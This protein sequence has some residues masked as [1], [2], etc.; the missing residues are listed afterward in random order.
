MNTYQLI[1][2]IRTVFPNVSNTQIRLDLD[3]AQK[4]LLSEV[5]LNEKSVL[6]ANPSVTTAWLLPSDFVSMNELVLFDAN[7]EP[8]YLE[9]KG[10]RYK[11]YQNYLVVYS[12]TS[13]VISGLDCTK[14]LL[15]YNSLPTTLSSESTELVLKEQYR[16]ALESYVLSKY[17]SK[18]PVE[19]ISNGQVVKAINLQLAQYHKTQYETLR[20]KL[21]KALGSQIKSTGEAIFYPHAGNIVLP[22]NKYINFLENTGIS[23]MA[24]QDLYSK[25][26]RFEV[27]SFLGT[28]QTPEYSVGF[29][30][31]EVD[32]PDEITINVL[33]LANEFTDKMILIPNNFDANWTK[34]NS[35]QITITL[36]AGSENFVFEIYDR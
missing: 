4:L 19:F 35:G 12:A 10:Y 18:Y 11:I 6:L 16:D 1:E 24:L 5:D 34:V 28:P 8:V 3:T 23:L 21:K 15:L 13:T 7:D 26:A 22:K 27:N 32:C 2:S 14:A 20:I 30:N 33:S 25:F 31:I 29:S 17:F 9:D 36:P